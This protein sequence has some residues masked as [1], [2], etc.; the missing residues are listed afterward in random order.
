[1][2]DETDAESGKR[3]KLIY[4]DDCINPAVDPHLRNK[5]APSIL[6]QEELTVPGKIAA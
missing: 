5:L 1:L 4:S 6:H 3:W 2:A